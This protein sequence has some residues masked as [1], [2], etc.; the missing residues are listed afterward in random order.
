MNIL[1][2][3]IKD[4]ISEINTNPNKIDELTEEEVIEYRKHLN[5]HKYSLFGP[6]KY[7]CLS[8]TNIREK[9]LQKLL[10]TA[11]I[12]FCYQL[13]NEYTIDEDEL[14]NPLNKED[15]KSY[16]DHPDKDNKELLDNLELDHYN[17]LKSELILS[18]NNPEYILS[19]DEEILLTTLAVKKVKDYI[20][21]VE[22]FDN[23]K[24]IQTQE[25]LINEQSEKEK[26]VIKRF[27]DKY[28][29]YDPNL[30]TSE[31]YKISENKETSN[32]KGYSNKFLENIP[33]N[34]VYNYFNHYYD[35]N[36]EELREAV[37]YLY[38]EHPDMELA[39]NIFESF[40]TL[41]EAQDYVNIN[42]DKLITDLRIVTNCKWAFL[43]SFK[44]NRKKLDFFNKNTKILENILKQQEKDTK[45]GE[46][47]LNERV[48]KKKIKNVKEYGKT[49]PSVLK[50]LNKD[51]D[52]ILPTNVTI[53]D[54]KVI[55]TEEIEISE[56]G[57]PVDSDGIPSDAV[58]IGIT[59][60]NLK[61]NSV[62]TSK[63]YTKAKSPE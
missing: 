8:L 14:D 35:V 20:S 21:P 27:L 2:D 18:K 32:E 55:V 49:D 15:F 45:L 40:D 51:K 63:I 43:A 7:T 56:N 17:K 42:K 30:H 57:A 28:F 10:T 58:E 26:K 34:D 59:S 31:N 1:S 12:G 13:N 62:E 29:K 52:E 5:P 50:Y 23:V 61:N 19:E 33:P 24:Y 54:D 48:H 53:T 38:A 44:E 11:L 37:S 39:L 22:Y 4:L 6:E 46:S 25:K 60:I 16:K 3:K 36:Y 41:Q 47:L 9:Y